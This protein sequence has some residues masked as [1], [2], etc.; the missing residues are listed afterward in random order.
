MTDVKKNVEDYYRREGHYGL[1]RDA[2]ED[3]F[4]AANPFALGDDQ[5]P[6]VDI[7]KLP[8]SL[9]VGNWMQIEDQSQQGACQGHAK[10]SSEELAIYRSTE[11]GILQ[12]CRQFSYITSQ[13]IDGIVGDRGSTIAGGAEA[14]KKYG[15]CLESLWP[16]TGRYD[17][18]IPQA[19]FADA[20]GRR[21]RTSMVLR[22]YDQVLRWLVH[23]IGGVVIG[24]GWN[25]SCTPDADG[26]ITS[27]HSGGGGHALAL[28][29]WSKQFLDSLGRPDIDLFN[30]WSK[31][32]GVAGRARIAPKVIEYWCE[33]ETVIGYS[34]MQG[35]DIKPRGFDWI[36]G[37]VI[38]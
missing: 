23:G 36:N 12:L 1:I 5:L 17:R 11:G 26:R 24:I 8:M 28:L 15:D 25:G 21:L 35:P 16:Y 30:S 37:H 32:W 22:S 3:R 18:N 13:M 34:D 6:P 10:T 33:N 38:A 19:C 29:D 7:E 31:R 27:Y 9:G 20:L 14:S 2:S 4:K